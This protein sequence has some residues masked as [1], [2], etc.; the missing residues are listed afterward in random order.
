MFVGQNVGAGA[1]RNVVKFVEKLPQYIEQRS[2]LGA[3]QIVSAN[4]GWFAYWA[5][6]IAA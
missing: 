3:Q 4:Q 2:A 5:V 6:I 1:F